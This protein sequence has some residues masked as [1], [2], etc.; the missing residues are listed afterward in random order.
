MQPAF[1]TNL[2]YEAFIERLARLNPSTGHEVPTIF[3]FKDNDI[4]VVH[5]DTSN[6]GNQ[7]GWR[8]VCRQ[9]RTHIEVEVL[10]APVYI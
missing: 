2:P 1:F 8:E 7:V 4:A 5:D 6:R 9:V 3:I 10:A